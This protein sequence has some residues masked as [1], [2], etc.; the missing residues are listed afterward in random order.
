MALDLAS[1]YATGLRTAATLGVTAPC[2]ITRPVPP[3]NPT[4]GIAS[5]TPAVSQTVDG[6]MQDTLRLRR[7]SDAWATAAVAVLVEAAMLSF[8]PKVGDTVQVGGR[9]LRCVALDELAP[10]GAVLAYVVGC[11]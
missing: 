8:A 6:L 2:T 1:F 11:G 4:T 5:R 9:T 10:A 3:P 7:T